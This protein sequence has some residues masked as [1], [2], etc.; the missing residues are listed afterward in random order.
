MPITADRVPAA[1]NDLQK[2]S[3]AGQKLIPT[4]F[5]NLTSDEIREWE[6]MLGRPLVRLQTQT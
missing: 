5:G 4:P 1:K 6:E 2:E 3:E